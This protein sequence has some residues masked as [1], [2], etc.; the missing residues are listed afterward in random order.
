MCPVGAI[1][2]SVA[3]PVVS[4]L[5]GASAAKKAASIQASAAN[6][7]TDTSLAMYKD[8]KGNL[9]P[10][11]DVGKSATYTLADL[12]GLPSPTNPQGGQPFPEASLA[13]FKNSPDYKFALKEGVG[14]LDASAASKGQLLSGNQ[15]KAIQDYGSGLATQNFGNY[16]TRLSDLAHLGEAAGSQSGSFAINTGQNVGSNQIA[17]GEANAAGTVGAYNAL[18]G[19]LNNAFNNY[20]TLSRLQTPG[21]YSSYGSLAPYATGGGNAYYPGPPGSVG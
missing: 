10:F 14:A 1:I 6:N 5:L 2:A 8:A 9:Q 4:G 18:G 11:T 13:A 20:L 21:N 12:Y 16:V 7:A 15:L 19:G 17:A 3:A